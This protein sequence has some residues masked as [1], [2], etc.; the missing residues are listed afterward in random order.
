VTFN[1]LP[2]LR[3]GR[4]NCAARATRDVFVVRW[5]VWI[6]DRLRG[7]FRTGEFFGHGISLQS[8]FGCGRSV[9]VRCKSKNRQSGWPVPSPPAADDPQSR[10][11][12]VVRRKPPPS[13]EPDVDETVHMQGFLSRQNRNRSQVSHRNFGQRL[14]IIKSTIYPSVERSGRHHAATGRSGGRTKSQ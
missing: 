1:E 6:N 11:F 5:D 8:P 14:N 12:G 4:K 7:T 10:L 2:E 3:Q 13:I 9:T